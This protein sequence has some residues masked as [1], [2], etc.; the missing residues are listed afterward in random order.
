MNEILIS[1][2]VSVFTKEDQSVNW[3]E[4]EQVFKGNL[5]ANLTDIVI[6]PEVVEEKLKILRFEK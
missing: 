5:N 1:Y 2:F 6:A 4:V 3:L